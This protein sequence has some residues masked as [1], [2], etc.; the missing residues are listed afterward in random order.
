MVAPNKMRRRPRRTK[1]QMPTTR[2][3]RTMRHSLCILLIAVLLSSCQ[4]R[5][6]HVANSAASIWEAAAAIRK[7]GSQPHCLAIIQ[8]QSHAIIQAMGHTYKPAEAG[9]EQ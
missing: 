7:G 1:R 6:Q 5:K 8:M 4:E 9:K 3:A 2:M